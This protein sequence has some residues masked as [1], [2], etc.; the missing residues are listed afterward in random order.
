MKI[1]YLEGIDYLNRNLEGFSKERKDTK[2]ALVRLIFHQHMYHFS[3]KSS[4]FV[5]I[6][7]TFM[8]RYLGCD[9]KTFKR[10]NNK[11]GLFHVEETWSQ[12]AAR[13]MQYTE[14]T[15]ALLQDFYTEGKPKLLMQSKETRGK[16]VDSVARM[17]PKNII[18]VGKLMIYNVIPVDM[19][20]LKHY[21]DHADGRKL[22]FACQIYGFANTEQFGWGMYPQEFHRSDNGR[23]TGVTNSLQNVDRDIRE[24]ALNGYYDYDVSNCHFAILEQVGDYPTIRDYVENTKQRR[25]QIAKDIGADYEDVKRCLLAM[26]YG[27]NRGKNE[28]KCAI[29][30]Y[31]G[32]DKVDMF[33]DHPYVVDLYAECKAAARKLL[34]VDKIDFKQ[35]SYELTTI[36]S[37]ILEDVTEGTIIH[38]PYFDGWVSDLPYDCRELERLIEERHGIRTTIKCRKIDYWGQFED[39]GA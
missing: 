20:A 16:I 17:R 31:L 18:K 29:A 26:L 1:L 12:G 6:S 19:A 35:L 4:E 21:I 25:N 13:K 36:E 14:K 7:V 33:W 3:D 23:V 8:E 38:V 10:L 39:N 22:V 28:Y 15:L 24:A 9:R 27:A 2:R 30:G 5:A 37:K 34:G 32:R 11:Y